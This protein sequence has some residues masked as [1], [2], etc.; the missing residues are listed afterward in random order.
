MERAKTL[1][2]AHTRRGWSSFLSTTNRHLQHA[3]SQLWRH[4]LP[5]LCYSWDQKLTIT[6][7]ICS[8]QNHHPIGTINL[9]QC[10]DTT[11]TWWD[12][13]KKE[14]TSWQLANAKLTEVGGRLKNNGMCSGFVSYLHYTSFV[15]E[16]ASLFLLILFMFM[17]ELNLPREDKKV[18]KMKI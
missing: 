6:H 11:P 2:Y 9:V 14:I 10:C 7:F 1:S 5:H 18:K 8:N 16:L 15:P 17:C 3:S 12:T 13:V 4:K